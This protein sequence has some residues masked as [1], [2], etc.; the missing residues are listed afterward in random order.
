[1]GAYSC[2]PS[3]LFV[4]Q[5]F[6]CFYSHNFVLP[7]QSLPNIPVNSHILRSTIIIHRT[8]DFILASHYF[9]YFITSFNLFYICIHIFKQ[10]S[11]SNRSTTGLDIALHAMPCSV[12]IRMLD[13][14][15]PSRRR[16][17]RFVSSKFRKRIRF[18]FPASSSS[19]AVLIDSF[20]LSLVLLPYS[21]SFLFLHSKN[22]TK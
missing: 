6:L 15:A 1:M 19:D 2:E 10:A 11:K 21:S 14:L 9:I 17:V 18:D 22:I 8:T 16:P 7:R 13:L 12:N 20:F 3:I 4:F 5:I